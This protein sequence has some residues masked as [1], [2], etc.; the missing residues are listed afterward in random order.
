VTSKRAETA[1]AIKDAMAAVEKAKA[2]N[3][4]AFR[5]ACVA[6]F[7]EYGLRLE[8]DGDLSAH[9]TIRELSEFERANLEELPE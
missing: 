6:L 2:A 8:A 1:R 4:A 5:A 7:N 9:L 3:R